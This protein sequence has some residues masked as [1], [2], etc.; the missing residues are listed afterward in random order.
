[1]K[2]ATLFAAIAV[3][4]VLGHNL[5]QAAEP[6]PKG[7]ASGANPPQA[8]VTNPRPQQGGAD[9][10]T[11]SPVRKSGAKN[12]SPAHRDMRGSQ[13]PQAQGMP[14][15]PGN[16]AA[17]PRA[18]GVR[19]P[20]TGVMINKDVIPMPRPD[21][22]HSPDAAGQGRAT[23]RASG[24]RNPGTGVMINK[25]VIPMPR[26]DETRVSPEPGGGPGSR[27]LLPGAPGPRPQP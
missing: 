9:S 12:L 18:G 20:G 13:R 11:L 19:N 4:L 25:D 24:P 27:Q 6:G 14:A 1:M 17:A 23:P 15:A 21:T 16:P 7:P 2:N 8:A 5:A 22:M 26:P 10:E 3:A